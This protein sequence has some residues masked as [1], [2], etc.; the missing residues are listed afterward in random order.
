MPSDNQLGSNKE[1]VILKGQNLPKLLTFIMNLPS[2]SLD[3]SD[4]LSLTSELL[5]APLTSLTPTSNLIWK[6][7]QV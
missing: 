4:I 6:A 7:S 2:L 5:R 3:Y 1:K